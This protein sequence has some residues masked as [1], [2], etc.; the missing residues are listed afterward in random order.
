MTKQAIPAQATEDYWGE[1]PHGAPPERVRVALVAES[2]PISADDLYAVLRRRLLT[3]SCIM[4]GIFLFVMG[5][6]LVMMRILPPDEELLPLP[7]GPF[8]S[9]LQNWSHLLLWPFRRPPSFYTTTAVE[10]GLADRRWLS[11]RWCCSSFTSVC[12]PIGF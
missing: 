4:T 10:L 11:G 9:I 3:L 1:P 5:I 7:S 6:S 8:E 12:P 2:G